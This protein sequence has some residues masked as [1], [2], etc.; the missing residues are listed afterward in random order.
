MPTL[1]IAALT[2]REAVRRRVA[3]V[4]AI[5]SLVLVALIAWGFWKLNGAIGNRTEAIGADAVLAILLAFM[6]S[7]VLGIGGAF[8]AAGSIAAEIDSGIALAVLPRPISRAQYVAGKWL[9]LV[10]LVISYAAVSGA[11]AFLA[12]RFAAGYD[13][14]NPLGALA[15]IIAQ[16]VALLTLALLL[17]TRL[18]ALAGGVLSV[19][20]FG[21]SWIAGI[22]AGVARALKA[23]TLAHVASAVGLLLPMDGLW[24]GAVFDLTP[25]VVQVAEATGHRQH[26]NPFGVTDPPTPAFLVWCAVWIAAVFGACVGSMRSRDI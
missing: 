17:S 15:Y 12:I 11:L 24:R 2:L 3:A 25:V 26:V 14:P 10:T 16:S 21:V 1:T 22:T 5:L 19:G 20:L 7:V 23:E 13:P 4:V 6:F 9:G 18:P 8:L